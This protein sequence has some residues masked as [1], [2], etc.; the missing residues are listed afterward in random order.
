MDYPLT[1][2][3]RG[4]FALQAGSYLFRRARRNVPFPQPTLEK[5]VSSAA[6][7]DRRATTRTSP[8]ASGLGHRLERIAV[9]PGCQT[10]WSQPRVPSPSSLTSPFMER[11]LG[12]G[13]TAAPLPPLASRAGTS[14]HLLLSEFNNFPHSSP[15]LIHGVCSWMELNTYKTTHA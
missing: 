2:T 7:C 11:R 9:L 5:N 14:R 13:A 6:H 8:S 4:F 10:R 3:H 12:C 1:L 15:S